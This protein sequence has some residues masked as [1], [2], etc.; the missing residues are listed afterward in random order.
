[1]YTVKQL[2]RISGVSVRTLHYYDQI[3]LL[4]PGSYAENGYREY[5]EPEALRLQQIL[6][7]RELGLPLARIKEILDNPDFDLLGALIVHK[8]LARGQDKPAF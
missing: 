6:F 2:A 8:N 7:F 5:G 1:M 3:G 4:T